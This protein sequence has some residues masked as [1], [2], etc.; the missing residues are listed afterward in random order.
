[1]TAVIRTKSHGVIEGGYFAAFTQFVRFGDYSTPTSRMCRLAARFAEN[2]EKRS[3]SLLVYL[4]DIFTER[5]DEYVMRLQQ[6]ANPQE[7]LDLQREHKIPAE[8][9]FDVF[10]EGVDIPVNVNCD[11]ANV[12]VYTLSPQELAGFLHYVARGGFLGWHGNS[13]DYATHAMEAMR[14]SKNPLF[15]F[16]KG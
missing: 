14:N 9:E 11:E 10:G 7:F 4:D 5:L 12:G 1:M 8:D 15:R 16:L 2:A 13:P 6:A 3:D